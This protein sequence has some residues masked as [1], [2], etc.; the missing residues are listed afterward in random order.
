MNTDGTV[1]VRVTHDGGHRLT[2]AMG[3]SV[4]QRYA[5]N[6]DVPHL[7]PALPLVAVADGMGDGRGSA[8]AGRTA[9]R[10][11]LEQ[12][13]AAGV[14][15]TPRI[16]RA[17]VAQAQ[18][19][20]RAAGAQL[21]ELTGCT[22]TA[23]LADSEGGAWIVHVGD[24]RVYRLRG[25]LLEL[26]TVDHSAA[27]LGAVY[28]WYPADSPAAARARYQLTRFVGH[29]DRAEPDVLNVSLRDGDVYCVC[30]DGV[31]EQVTY[32]RLSQALGA[33][34]PGEAVT[35]VL[36]DTQAAGGRDNATAA[37]VRVDLATAGTGAAGGRDNAAALVR[38][39]LDAADT[40]RR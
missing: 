15:A 16:L 8:V 13:R 17:A 4:G 30:T 14:E 20:V 23:W 1:T 21:G 26:L 5:A 19:R 36:A 22:L 40:A 10:V 28:G 9:M 27:W 18:Q 3:T 25:G 32:R 31:A 12:V 2:M 33:A 24:S 38:V 6:F 37:V 7:D 39:D 29:P 35:R 34:D 11:F